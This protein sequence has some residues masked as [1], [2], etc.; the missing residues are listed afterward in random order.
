MADTALLNDYPDDVSDI[1]IPHGSSDNPLIALLN[2]FAPQSKNKRLFLV[3]ITSV[4]MYI[5][6]VVQSVSVQEMSFVMPI[7]PAWLLYFTTF[8][9]ECDTVTHC[10]GG[11]G[12]ESCQ[13]IAFITLQTPFFSE[14]LLS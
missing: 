5:C 13:K 11:T 10:F 8:S 2:Q 7:F 1:R 6:G 3:L 14:L 9:C 12:R 4:A